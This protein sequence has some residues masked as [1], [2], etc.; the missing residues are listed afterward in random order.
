ME[1]PADEKRLRQVLI[2]IVGN[3]VKFTEKGE[4]KVRL[5]TADGTHRPEAVEVSDTG[6]GIQQSGLEQIFDAFHQADSSTTRQYG[7]TGLGLAIS[8][9]FCRLMGF[10]LVA[11]SKVGRGSTFTI[12]LNTETR[13]EESG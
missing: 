1:A 4:I 13:A 11:A 3:A 5:R 12:L 8:R 9:S 10:D 2:N 7:G 6:I